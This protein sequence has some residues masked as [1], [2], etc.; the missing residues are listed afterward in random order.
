MSAPVLLAIEFPNKITSTFNVQIIGKT[1]QYTKTVAGGD[2]MPFTG[3][4]NSSSDIVTLGANPNL[5]VVIKS[6]A[7]KQGSG[8]F[9]QG[10]KTA[11]ISWKRV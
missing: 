5:Q 7:M 6:F 1:G 2:P 11:D 9:T 4:A 10:G 8:S 3:L